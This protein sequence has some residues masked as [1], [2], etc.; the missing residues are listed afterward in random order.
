MADYGSSFFQDRGYTARP[1]ESSKSKSDQELRQGFSSANPYLNTNP[2]FVNYGVGQ[3]YGFSSAYTSGNSQNPPST[4]SSGV[5]GGGESTNIPYNPSN[6]GSPPTDNRIMP[7]YPQGSIVYENTRGGYEILLPSNVTYLREQQSGGI[8]DI[9]P[10]QLTMDKYNEVGKLQSALSTN[11][12][13]Q[14]RYYIQERIDSITG[15]RT[16]FLNDINSMSSGEFLR[17]SREFVNLGGTAELTIGEIQPLQEKIPENNTQ[18]Q[19]YMTS[20]YIERLPPHQEAINRDIEGMQLRQYNFFNSEGFK[21]VEAT[22][23]LLTF[24]GG[25]PISERSFFGRIAQEVIEVPLLLGTPAFGGYLANIGEKG[26]ILGEKLGYNEGKSFME[27][28]QSAIKPTITETIKPSNLIVAGIFGS[29]DAYAKNIKNT[30]DI[31]FKDFKDVKQTDQDTIFR[32]SIDRETRARYIETNVFPKTD[33]VI[34]DLVKSKQSI[35]TENPTEIKLKFDLFDEGRTGTRTITQNLDTGTYSIVERIQKEGLFFSNAKDFIKIVDSTGNAGEYHVQVFKTQGYLDNKNPIVDKMFYDYGQPMSLGTSREYLS[36]PLLEDKPKFTREVGTDIYVRESL[37]GDYLQTTRLKVSTLQQLKL[38]K[39]YIIDIE[40]EY[41]I[42]LTTKGQSL[43]VIEDYTSTKAIP[44]FGSDQLHANKILREG[45]RVVEQKNPQFISEIRQFKDVD[46]NIVKLSPSGRLAYESSLKNDIFFGKSSLSELNLPELKS[47]AKINKISIFEPKSVGL[48]S[49]L[50]N[51]E[52]SGLKVASVSF[53]SVS[54]KGYENLGKLSLN[55]P[56]LKYESPR[57]ISTLTPISLLKDKSS[58]SI[59]NDILY[60]LRQSQKDN[61]RPF[62][63]FNPKN[64]VFLGS[65]QNNALRQ[66]QIQRQE[67]RQVQELRSDVLLGSVQNNALKQ[68]QIQ[69]QDQELRSDNFFGLSQPSKLSFS[70][71][72]NINMPREKFPTIPLLLPF[73]DVSKKKG[74]NK[75]LPKL[76]GFNPKSSKSDVYILPDLRSVS[77]TESKLFSF[78]RKSDRAF[79][80]KATSRVKEQALFAF[81]GYSSGFIPT[82]QIRTGKIKKLF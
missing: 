61:S 18:Y 59:K 4:S 40:K 6:Y 56:S 21:N 79:I 66:S 51:P 34:G 7:S 2:E 82:E 71:P 15:V 24:G 81:K 25:V 55:M 57:S 53:P 38:E 11:I 22:A 72:R 23:N 69:R 73:G 67:L 29:M 65:V 8:S 74:S 80:P 58:I 14:S 43:G 46:I 17:A 10:P 31:V 32:Q 26:Y 36:N 30:N 77:V 62:I 37:I 20:N 12:S 1:E 9:M 54:S 42:R 75:R 49:I 16:S 60:G 35:I 33:Y 28:T 45:F 64:D 48:S 41:G 5:R 44:E 47:F 19:Q 13:P 27:D 39:P 76:F 63:D 78:G 3:P 68:S 70:Q 52:K 50:I